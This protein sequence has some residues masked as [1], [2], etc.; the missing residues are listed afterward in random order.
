MAETPLPPPFCL[1]G[2]LYLLAAS[3]EHA[4]TVHPRFSLPHSSPTCSPPL[5][6]L[7]T[8]NAASCNTPHSQDTHPP[9]LLVGDSR[10]RLKTRRNLE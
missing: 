1:S 10:L 6:T 8:C 3:P 7:P 4:L 2:A 5:P 9:M